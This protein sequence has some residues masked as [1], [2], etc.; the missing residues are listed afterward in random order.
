MTRVLLTGSTGVIGRQAVQV[1]AEA[2]FDVHATHHREPVPP[3]TSARWHRVDLL[4]RDS[5]VELCEQVEATH[6]VHLAWHTSQSRNAKAIEHLDWVAASLLLLREFIAQGGRRAVVAGTV[7]EYNWEVGTCSETAGMLR[8][9]SRYAISKHLLHTA[10]SALWRGELSLAWARIFFVYGPDSD[11][12][13]LVS[14]VSRSLLC[15]EPALCSSGTQ[16]RDY[17]YSRDV[18]SAITAL[19]G[20]E[21]QGAVNIGSGEDRPVRDLIDAVA[22]E[23][24]RPDLVRLGALAGS[25]AE[26]RRITADTGRLRHEVGWSPQVSLEEGVAETVAWWRDR[27][28]DVDQPVRSPAGS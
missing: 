11:T 25:R 4:D 28:A 2:G 19:L 22:A 18:A 26:P 6:L 12:N 5:T 24:G 14:S 7:A 20:S 8:P 1:L 9:R 23:V 13:R 27:L 16:R 21:V 17:L 10:A 3:Q 15:G